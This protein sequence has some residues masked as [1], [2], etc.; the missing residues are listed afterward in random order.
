MYNYP[1]TVHEEVGSFWSSCPDIPEAHSAGDTIEELRTNAV[2][3]IKLALTIYVDQGRD[4]PPASAPV[5]GQFVV[6]LPAQTVAKI[7]LWNTMRAKG[8]RVADLA[9][10]VG[11]SHPVANRLVDFDHNSKIEQIESALAALGAGILVQPIDPE[12]VKIQF[13]PAFNSQGNRTVLVKLPTIPFSVLPEVL[14]KEYEGIPAQ[15]SVINLNDLESRWW[16]TKQDAQNLKTK[17]WSAFSFA[18]MA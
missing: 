4:I 14:Q 12:A 17:G 15:E 3:G 18:S 9:R 8:L 1:I 16:L 7:T 13:Y 11:V 6:S 2:E 5:E 10:T